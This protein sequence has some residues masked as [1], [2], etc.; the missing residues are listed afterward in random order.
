[1]SSREAAFVAPFCVTV[2]SSLT[3]C[4]G[5]VF[6]CKKKKTHFSF[7][8]FREENCAA[9][10]GVAIDSAGHVVL[11]QREVDYRAKTGARMSFESGSKT[12]RELL[13]TALEKENDMSRN[14]VPQQL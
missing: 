4:I 7:C 13:R 6:L 11:E 8:P 5:L 3:K 1:M 12:E 10:N 9:F 2:S 14:G